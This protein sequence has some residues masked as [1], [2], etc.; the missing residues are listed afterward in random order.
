MTIVTMHEIDEAKLAEVMAEASKIGSV[1]LNVYNDGNGTYHTLEG[2]HRTEA[3]KRLGLPLILV[4]REWDELVECDLQ[5]IEIE[6]GKAS[7]QAIVEYAYSSYTGG[8]YS[9]NDFES[10]EMK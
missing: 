10:V 5:D 2:V 4:E 3:A 6:D 1:T 8:I 7:V 9:E